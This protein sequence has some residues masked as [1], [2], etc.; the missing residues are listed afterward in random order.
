MADVAKDC[1]KLQCKH[2]KDE[3]IIAVCV[4][5]REMVCAECTGAHSLHNLKA[6]MSDV[7]M[8]DVKKAWHQ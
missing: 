2:H 4:D 3:D 8:S 6:T 1:S 5:C 7:L